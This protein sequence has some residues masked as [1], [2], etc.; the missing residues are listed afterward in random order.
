MDF[1]RPYRFLWVIKTKNHETN[2]IG[3]RPYLR[4][5]HGGLTLDH[6]HVRPGALDMK[7]GALIGYT[8]MVIA[9]RDFLWDKIAPR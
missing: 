9:S 7:N 1:E 3:L 5:H 8:G 2:C 6:A 4:S